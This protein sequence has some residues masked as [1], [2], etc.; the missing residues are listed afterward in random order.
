[1]SFSSCRSEL[2]ATSSDCGARCQVCTYC[3][4]VEIIERIDATEAE[5]VPARFRCDSIF[6]EQRRSQRVN[7]LGREV[8]MHVH[9]FYEHETNL[10]I[11]DPGPALIAPAP[12]P[13]T[14][15]TL[16]MGIPSPSLSSFRRYFERARRMFNNNIKTRILVGLIVF[17]IGCILF[18]IRWMRADPTVIEVAT[19]LKPSE[20]LE[21]LQP[22][23]P[24]QPLP[25]NDVVDVD[26]ITNPL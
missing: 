9:D 3:K 23:Q 26:G 20:P 17:G 16:E 21:P 14:L 5:C 25:T 11:T 6:N 2:S 19:T 10:R 24:L 1:M 7:T 12:S 8:L 13:S 15:S 4:L 22:L 18:Y